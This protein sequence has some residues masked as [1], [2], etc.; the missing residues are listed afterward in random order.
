MKELLESILRTMEAVEVKG[1][2]NLDKL[3]GCM[4]AL[5]EVIKL[6]GRVEEENGAGENADTGN[7]GEL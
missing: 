3:L 4:N 5:E 6:L 7:G 1:R 2:G